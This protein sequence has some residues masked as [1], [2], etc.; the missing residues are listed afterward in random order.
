MG[1]TLPVS[2]NPFEVLGVARDVSDGELK[3]RYFALLRQFPPESHPEEFSRVQHAYEQLKDSAARARFA[4]ETEPYQGVEEPYRTRLREA[5]AQL[6]RGDIELA[7]VALKAMVAEKPDLEDARNLLHHVFFNEENF[8]DA[9]AQLQALVQQHPDAAWY[10]YRHA[11]VL[12]RLKRHADAQ[13][14]SE[15]W[16]KIT[17]GRDPQAWDF[18]A[19][20]LAAQGRHDEALARLD[21]G[22]AAVPH[23]APLIL[24]RMHLRLDRPDRAALERDLAELLGTIAPGDDEMKQVSAERLQSLAALFFSRA[25]SDEANLL[26]QKVRELSGREGGVQF[27]PRLEVFIEELPEP[28]QQWLVEESQTAHI[29]RVNRR[30]KLA[31]VLLALLFT[32]LWGLV[33]LV[34]V[35]NESGWPGGLA[36]VYGVLALAVTAPMVWAWRELSWSF[37]V[38]HRRMISVH[39]LYMLEVGVE[40]LVAWPL[41]NLAEPKLL[42]QYMNGVYSATTITLPFGKKKMKVQIRGQ[43][44]ALAFAQA[45][46]E[47]RYRALQLMHGGLL[48]A[49]QGFDFIPGEFL[50]PTFRSKV[51]G[52]KRAA[53]AKR[54]GYSVAVAVGLAIAAALVGSVRERERSWAA[55]VNGGSAVDM[56]KALAQ[57]PNGEGSERFEAFRQATLSAA[58]R[59]LEAT[60]DK[61]DPRRVAL[62]ALM[63]EVMKAKHPLLHFRSKAMPPEGATG[64]QATS[65]SDRELKESMGR[66]PLRLYDGFSQ[67]MTTRAREV[68]AVSA[69]SAERGVT[70]EVALTPRLLGKSVQ[71][72]KTRWPLLGL[73]AR[74]TLEGQP[75]ADVQVDLDDGDAVVVSTD[76]NATAVLDAQMDRLL[77]KV[78]AALARA[79]GL[80]V[81]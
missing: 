17:G 77:S 46:H 37:A 44:D 9:E 19:E 18:V 29:R 39:P 45:L 10:R 78:G 4:E 8:A 79:S 66:F 11:L 48:E 59:D 41:V 50:A 24:T 60:L 3:K 38:P 5:L 42:H 31:D 40:K 23:R 61:G 14:A 70:I 69:G 75:L 73:T 36:V 81:N 16:V 35:V 80:S 28:S 72:A 20:S 34:S 43:Q 64:V 56:A 7:R 65:F 49:E 33:A 53:R 57:R 58:R 52:A 13:A 27:P 76:D 22:L 12:T 74:A 51:K 63:S 62:G 47:Y 55:A 15:A 32:A 68:L 30:G 6:Q 25:L 54:W 67:A 71:V 26:L 2:D 1:S 21:Q